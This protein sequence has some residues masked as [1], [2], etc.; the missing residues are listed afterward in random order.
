MSFR[1]DLLLTLLLIGV[2]CTG[3]S[4]DMNPGGDH[5]GPVSPGDRISLTNPG[6]GP[7][8]PQ[9]PISPN[10]PWKN[11][12]SDPGAGKMNPQ[13]LPVPGPRTP[14]SNPVPAP[15]SPV[16]VTDHYSRPDYPSHQV[17]NPYPV[18]NDPDRYR[19]VSHSYWNDDNYPYYSSNY[20]YRSGSLQILST[21]SGASVYLNNKYRGRTP[22][23]G[24]LDIS[25]LQSGSYDLLIQYD[26]Y[27]PYTS[28]IYIER[29]QVRT[30]NVVLTP[31]VEQVSLTGTMQI[32]S[33]PSDAQVFLNHQFM[34]ITPV[35]L[36]SLAPGGY[37]LTLQKDGYSSY[38]SIVQVIS[39]QT[40]PIT[41][42]LSSVPS[43]P[44]TP[45]PTQTPV[46]TQTPVP[47][48]TRAGLPVMVILIGLAAGL[49]CVSRR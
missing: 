18:Y 3:C 19:Y 35:S 4:A 27:L 40:L 17:S 37:T 45:V 47:A 11:P 48:P 41:A 26:D 42:V 24:Y 8:N 23:T 7:G 25:S 36:S 2:L 33:E 5:M 21:P 9:S 12:V 10:P 31:G 49:W 34:G 15:L 1:I 22:H 30:V 16:I 44:A 43:T 6:M 39:G 13:I 38:T 46:Q 29:N 14:I 28:T 20:Y 32:Q